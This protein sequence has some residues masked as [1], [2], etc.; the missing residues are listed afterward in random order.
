MSSISSNKQLTIT[1]L[2][3]MKA[4][5]NKITALTAYDASFAAQFDQAGVELLL[6]GDSLGNVIQGQT[7]T[8]P[9]SVADMVYHTQ[10][11]VRATKQAYVAVDMPFLSY[12]HRHKAIDNAALLMQQG[13]ANMV[14]LEC[15]QQHI[16]LVEQMV[17]EGI[18]V[19]VH[20]GLRPQQI[21]KM[22]KYTVQGKTAAAAKQMQQLAK[23]F[24]DVGADLL[25]LES[26]PATLAATI[27]AQS[28]VPVIGIGAG[29]DCDGQILVCYDMLGI[30]VGH[31]PKFARNFLADPGC[32]SVAAAVSAYVAAVKDKHFPA[33]E[34]CFN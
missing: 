16:A 4:Q 33:D 27:T 25:L 10:C 11:V 24:V 19:C 15:D 28:A 13:G 6:V 34:H 29:R 17:N 18:P 22:G 1:D 31:T 23:Q 9:V 2:Q 14:K 32:Q 12:S 7:S 8:L 21:E 30:T 5:Q 26:V 3:Q 20:L